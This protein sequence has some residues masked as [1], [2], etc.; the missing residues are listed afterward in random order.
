MPQVERRRI[1]GTLFSSTLF[2]GRAPEGHVALTTFIGGMRQPE[3]AELDE[4]E[5]LQVVQEELGRLV[6]VTAPPVFAHVKRW[7]RAIPQYTLGYQRFKDA[8]A[9]VES[10][11]P[12]LFI[13]GNCRDGISL[14][15][16]IGSGQRMAR[17]AGAFA[18]EVIVPIRPTTFATR[19]A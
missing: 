16:C 10:T 5:L 12:G 6:G 1:L 15:N 7:P 18:N 17:L 19:V 11:V 4:R 9:A 13:G 2:P 8:I 3:L 14:A